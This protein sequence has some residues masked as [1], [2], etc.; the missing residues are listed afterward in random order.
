MSLSRR[1]LWARRSTGL[2]VG[3]QWVKA[4]ELEWPGGQPRVKRLLRFAVP[5][6]A[7]S[8]GAADDPSALAGGL[9]AN[10]RPQLFTSRHLALSVDSEQVFLRSL[11]LP[12]LA[13]RE[14]AA[15]ARWE[16]ES[17]LPMPAAEVVTDY[18]VLGDDGP[19]R[20][21]VMM[22]GVPRR[23]V[24]GYLAACRR[25]GLTPEAIEP[26]S[27]AIWRAIQSDGS[28]PQAEDRS[29]AVL[30]IGASALRLTILRHGTPYLSRTVA[31]AG[32]GT[33]RTAELAREVRTSL[34]FFLYDNRGL[35]LSQV[36]LAGGAARDQGLAAFLEEA[37]N[38]AFLGRVPGAVPITASTVKP[39]LLSTFGEAGPEFACALGLALRGGPAS[40]PKFSLLPP[41]FRGRRRRH[42]LVWTAALGAVGLVAAIAWPY[43]R[44]VAAVRQE[45]AAVAVAEREARAVESVRGRVAQLA[46]ERKGL[47]D[48]LTVL[49]GTPG[50]EGWSP[51][52]SSILT[53]IPP[54]VSI[55]QVAAGGSEVVISGS[56]PRLD[57]VRQLEIQLGQEPGYL[58]RVELKSLNRVGEVYQFQLT[59]QVAWEATAP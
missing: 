15:A 14:L 40:A 42:R 17:H 18:I 24:Q 53:A 39:A 5:E 54:G 3:S 46:A 11:R 51:V 34:E 13:P 8:R 6:G 10:L 41:Q 33:A 45:A 30:D 44:E 23:V 28:G 4:V 56:A 38:T 12:Q 9:L 2:D 52:L 55:S 27:T 37:L 43:V 31:L 48:R 47:A 57:L 16:G 19:G 21:E 58:A 50:G 36:Y 25:A 59:V 29:V 1:G 35:R 20:T 26:E 22:V 7:M 32:E 49:T